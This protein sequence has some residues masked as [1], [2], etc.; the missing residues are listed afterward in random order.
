[1]FVAEA[2]GRIVGTASLAKF[3]RIPDADEEYACLTVFVLPE[4]HGKGI[5]RILMERVEEAAR[6]RGVQ[7]L[8]VPASLNALQFY[9]KQRDTRRTQLRL[10]PPK[11]ATYGWS[12]YWAR[13]RMPNK[14]LERTRLNG[15]PLTLNVRL[16]KIISSNA[17]IIIIRESILYPK[18]RGEK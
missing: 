7:V 12:K 16:E 1:M 13:Q 4:S 3:K 9:R 17:L 11:K 18:S 2:D 8:R 6:V 10:S 15:A 5:E 14:A